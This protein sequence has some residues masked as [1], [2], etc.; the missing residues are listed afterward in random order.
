MILPKPTKL[1]E[2]LYLSPLILLVS[3]RFQWISSRKLVSWTARES[4]ARWRGFRPKLLRKTMARATCFLWGLDAAEFR[5][6][7]EW[8][9]RLRTWRGT[10]DRWAP[11][12]SRFIAMTFQ[13]WEHNRLSIEQ[14]FPATSRTGTLC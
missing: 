1:H 3:I 4:I 11:S 6:R 14:N 12:T 5:L 13:P 9:I 7:S 10:G 8:R 2:C